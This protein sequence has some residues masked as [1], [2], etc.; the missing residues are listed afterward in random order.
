MRYKSRCND[1]FRRAAG[2]YLVYFRYSYPGVHSHDWI[3]LPHGA[4]VNEVAPGVVLVRPD[5]GEIGFNSLFQD[6]GPAAEPPDI[7]I[8]GDG[9]AVAGR[10]VKSRYP[11]GAAADP[12]GQGALGDQLELAFSGQD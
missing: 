8:P 11:G 10:R 6:A 5:Q 12:L 4:A 1:R 7:F 9:R 2:S 3:E